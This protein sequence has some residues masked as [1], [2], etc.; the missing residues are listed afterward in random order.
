[1]A[2]TEAVQLYRS[3]LRSSKL[4]SQYNFREY[5]LRRTREEFRAH[6]GESDAAKIAELI[7]RGK[8]E[9]QVI[10]RQATLS[11]LFR[12]NQKHVVELRGTK[13]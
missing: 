11:T 1:M 9:L 3:L 2:S 13:N 7:G 10:H 8:E 4:F 5:F 12:E 6:R